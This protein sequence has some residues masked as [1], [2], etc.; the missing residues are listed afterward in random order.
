MVHQTDLKQYDVIIVG[1][2]FAGL[3]AA[4]ELSMLGHSVILLEGR[5][6]L[7]GRTWTDHQL[8]CDLEM[9]GT[10]VHWYQPHVWTEITRYGLEIYQAP[11]AQKAYWITGGSV[12]SGT[13]EELNSIVKES[14]ERLMRQANK[15]LPLP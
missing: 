9:G 8:G 2:G 7:G 15:H 4:R 11:S 6:R 5:D 10:Y 14:F 12:H 1:A 13:P 3:V